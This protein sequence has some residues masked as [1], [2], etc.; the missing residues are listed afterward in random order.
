MYSFKYMEEEDIPQVISL[1]SAFSSESPYTGRLKTEEELESE[2]KGMLGT[3]QT[4][5]LLKNK[6]VVGFISGIV[7]TQPFLSGKVATEL[8][9]FVH[10][11]HRGS[12]KSL[13]LVVLFERW[14]REEGADFIHM[15]TLSTSPVVATKALLKMGYRHGESLY[16]KES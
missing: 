6:T 13:Q 8:G 1:M 4:I 7:V 9:W 5:L 16:Y 10:P 2:I 14:A 3:I 12:K 15:S 11:D